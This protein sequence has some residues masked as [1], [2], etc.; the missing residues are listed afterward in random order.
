MPSHFELA[1]D[2][3]VANELFD[4]VTDDVNSADPENPTKDDV[5][6]AD[7]AKLADRKYAILRIKNPTDPNKG[8]LGGGMFGTVNRGDPV[9]YVPITLQYRPYTAD[10]APE[11]S[12][13]GF[14]VNGVK[15]NRTY[16]GKSTTV[17][18]EGDLD[19]VIKI[20]EALPADAKLICIVESSKPMCYYELEPYCDV[21]LMSF[22]FSGVPC[23][24]AYANIIVG[25]TEPSGLL[26]FQQPIDMHTVEAQLEDVPRDMEPYVDSEG[27]V[28]DFAFGLNWSGKI[29]DDRV[30]TYGVA[31]LTEPQVPVIFG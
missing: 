15:E 5:V 28:Y 11:V 24:E 16:K 30:K 10:T 26:P 7:A 2:E 8:I 17:T 3:E 29:D 23:N 14:I 25:K 9:E 18:N 12:I 21:I 22:S 4:A 20:R 6:C 19:T 27:N 1:I 13:G 31:P